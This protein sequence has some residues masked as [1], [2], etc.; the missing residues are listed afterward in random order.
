MIENFAL[1]LLVGFLSIVG[2]LML[3]GALVAVN[4]PGVM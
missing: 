3:L 2:G 4:Y 1:F